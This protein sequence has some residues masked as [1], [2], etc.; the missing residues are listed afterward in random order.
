MEWNEE[1]VATL[2]K[3]WR[4]GYSASQVAR[5][6]GGVSR[7]AVIGKVH[8][9]GLAGRDAPS[10]P[11]SPGGRPSTRL[12]ATAGGTRR[13]ATPVRQAR[14]EAPAAPRVQIELSP[15]ATLVT[16]TE[17]ACRWPI[18]DPDQPGFGFCG[19]LKA[20]GTTYCTGHSAMSVRRRDA[21]LRTKEIDHLVHRYVEG[22]TVRP[23]D[24]RWPELA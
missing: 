18:G 12:R 4:E 17:H 23:L 6:L 22:A 1:R 9:L 16:L 11:H 19:R 2:T 24:N 15:T 3:L 14:Q 13:A 20:H 10:R 21:P 7:S 8:R 5:Q